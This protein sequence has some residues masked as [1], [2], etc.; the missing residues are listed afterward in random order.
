MRPSKKINEVSWGLLHGRR[1][2][3]GFDV[4]VR[5]E[6][7]LGVWLCAMW[8]GASACDLW[9]A[10]TRVTPDP[11]LVATLDAVVEDTGFDDAE[12]EADLFEPD[13]PD[14]EFFEDALYRCQPE[15]F[16][17]QF[18]GPGGVCFDK[19]LRCEEPEQTCDPVRTPRSDRFFCESLFDDGVGV[20]REICDVSNTSACGDGRVCGLLYEGSEIAVCRRRC[21]GEQS[22][23]APLDACVGGLFGVCRGLCLPFFEG[24]CPAD[25]A[26]VPEAVERGAC[27]TAR[28]TQ[29]GEDC[30]DVAC[31]D[32][33]L[34]VSTGVGQRCLAVCD[35]LA[36]SGARGA[37]ADAQSQVCDSFGSFD[38][39]LC[40]ARCELFDAQQACQD[41]L[42]GC[43]SVSG[44]REGICF[45]KGVIAEGNRCTGDAQCAG[46]LLC[47]SVDN[48][49]RCRRPC[50]RGVGE[51][52]S[53]AC[54][55]GAFC[56]ML[57]FGALG[58]CSQ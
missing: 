55:G 57:D 10:P 30:D 7:L 51:G 53:G 31:G 14:G 5:P 17:D 2:V 3:S 12:T 19:R 45:Y 33:Q 56:Q 48:E 58:Y 40:R 4:T 18:C 52:E 39:G 23:C 20:C 35:P 15:C 27:Q 32:G 49:R 28:A 54:P 41:P 8:C 29:V 25:T 42:Q 1:L 38:L 43:V 11:G 47:L 22:L 50:L 37:C 16:D 46:D 36:S 44:G 21:E 34:C 26:C 9:T 24:Q 13:R 6:V